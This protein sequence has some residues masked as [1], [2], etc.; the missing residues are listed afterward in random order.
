MGEQLRDHGQRLHHSWTCNPEHCSCGAAALMNQ[1]A[2]EI[3]RLQS[4]LREIALEA[5]PR[6]S[7]RKDELREMA[8]EALRE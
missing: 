4:V 5:N 8:R 3:E 2:D 7:T 1:A 6:T